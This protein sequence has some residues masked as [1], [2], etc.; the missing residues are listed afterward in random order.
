MSLAKFGYVWY[1]EHSEHPKF[2]ERKARE[3]LEND[4]CAVHEVI[5][6]AYLRA[7]GSN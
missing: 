3:P 4:F 2:R 1:L 5:F 7:R 6:T